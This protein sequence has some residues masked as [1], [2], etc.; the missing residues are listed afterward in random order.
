MSHIN[1]LMSFTQNFFMNGIINSNA[2]DEYYDSLIKY[3]MD[4]INMKNNNGDTILLIITKSHIKYKFSSCNL[5]IKILKYLIMHNVNLDEQDKGDNTILILFAQDYSWRFSYSCLNII[6]F[7]LTQKIN[8]NI[9]NNYGHTAITF[10]LEKICCDDNIQCIKLL[11]KQKLNVF[12][13][14]GDHAHEILQVIYYDKINETIKYL[15]ENI[16]IIKLFKL[17][18]LCYHKN[19]TY[20]YIYNLYEKYIKITTTLLLCS[21]Y[22]KISI[23]EQIKNNYLPSSIFK[24]ICM[25]I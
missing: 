24:K 23:Y 7:L 25:Y 8:V 3:P 1:D 21:K 5:Y 22:K 17:S 2:F 10:M 13:N 14:N 18:H 9:R 15:F 16:N 20:I 6:T 12:I 11:I 4:Q 19:I